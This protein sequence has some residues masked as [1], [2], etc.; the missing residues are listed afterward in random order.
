MRRAWTVLGLLLIPVLAGLGGLAR[1]G[2]GPETFGALEVWIDTGSERL[3]AWQL[4]LTSPADGLR[5]SAVEGGEP[6][7]FGEAPAYD[8]AA[9]RGGRLILAAY[10]GPEE[11]GEPPAGR[12]RVA[13]LHYLVADAD[14]IEFAVSGVV[15]A[16][17][18]G[19]RRDFE[20]TLVESP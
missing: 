10:A 11:A 17:T 12:V 14:A 19:R 15:T 18:S 8:P 6:G 5:Y 9:L 1:T 4:E 20:V 13:R 3:G 16:D 2:A 7:A